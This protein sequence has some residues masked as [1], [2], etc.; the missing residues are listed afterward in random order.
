MKRDYHTEFSITNAKRSDTGRYTLKA[1]NSSGV[2]TETVD[3]TVLGKPGGKT[4]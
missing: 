2:D 3:L 1:E 4:R